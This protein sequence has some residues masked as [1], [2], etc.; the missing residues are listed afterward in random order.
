MNTKC[1]ISNK[2]TKTNRGKYNGNELNC[3]TNHPQNDSSC[4]YE[5]E[6]SE[7]V[8]IPCKSNKVLQ[9]RNFSSV[10]QI[11]DSEC[12][13]IQKNSY[14]NDW[15]TSSDL[16]P[17]RNDR[18]KYYSSPR[19]RLDVVQ[20]TCHSELVSE[21]IL[22]QTLKQVQGDKITRKEL[23]HLF[24]SKKLPSPRIIPSAANFGKTPRLL[25]SAGFTLA[26]VLIT[27]G[28]IGVVAALTIPGLINNY[29]AHRLHT[30]FLKSYSTIQQA[31]K[32][33]EADD[34]S[35][36]PTTYRNSS[37]YKTFMSYLNA[38]FNC[39]DNETSKQYL[40][41]YPFN[42]TAEGYKNLTNTSVIKNTLFDD[43]QIALQDGT[44][45]AFENPSNSGYI[46][47]FTDLN[48]Y[49]NLPNKLGYNLFAFQFLDGELKTM[50]DKGTN[51]T[52][53]S[54]YCDKNS[55]DKLN[56]IACAYKAKNDPDYFKSVVKN[57]K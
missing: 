25:R 19:G 6:R 35:L 12:A 56:G 17:P 34:V 37:F 10:E 53:L 2:T 4:H 11:Q 46:L 55:Q 24:T 49:N 41:C 50:G 33:M 48:G 52:D 14:R 28:I 3:K 8:V 13:A 23:I 26:E 32:Q 39:R 7:D 16:R 36:D 57:F 9:L 1:K 43:G 5:S 27:I 45:L 30:Q 44:L 31:F 42:N 54:I 15:I 40:P 21:S 18:G 29:K 20:P 22:K 47:V 38:P 51:Y